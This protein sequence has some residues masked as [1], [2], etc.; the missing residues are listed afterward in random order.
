MYPPERCDI[1][2]SSEAH[3]GRDLGTCDTT[4]TSA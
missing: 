2:A 4:E 1:A 3:L